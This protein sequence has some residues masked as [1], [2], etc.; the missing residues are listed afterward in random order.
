M[1]TPK[2]KT[3]G[4]KK[5]ISTPVS[6]D[7]NLGLAAENNHDFGL[8]DS[9]WPR[10]DVDPA[11]WDKYC[12]YQLIIVEASEDQ[13]KTSYQPYKGW[14]YTLPLPP[15]S[16]SI[17][18]PFAIQL[19]PTLGGFIEEHNGA[20]L[21]MI[22]IRGTTGFLPL[23]S[24]PD[25][26]EGS[27]ASKEAAAIFGGTVTVANN[28]RSDYSS[29]QSAFSNTGPTA[30]N[31][32][33]EA[34]FSSSS[35]EK[36][37]MMTSGFV[38]IS[39][40]RN[41]LEAYAAIKKTPRGSSL[42]LAVA[43]WKEDQVYLVTPMGFG[44]SKD[45]SSPMEYRYNLSFKA[46]KR[47]KLEAGGYAKL[48]PK[49]IRRDP[50]QIARAI[51]TLT[52]ARRMVQNIGALKQGLLGDVDYVF[53]PLHDVIL[54]GKDILGT[55]LTLAEIPLA[56]RQRVTIN[57]MELQYEYPDLYNEYVANLPKSGVALNK[58]TTA[59]SKILD[60]PEGYRHSSVIEQHGKARN[61][62]SN[63]LSL[64]DIPPGLA[65]KLPLQSLRLP[66]DA[67]NDIKRDLDRVR[68]LTRKDFENYF[69]TMQNVVNK[70]T[71]LLGA[72]DADFNATYGISVNSTHTPTKSDWDTIIALTE[73]VEV[74][75]QFAATA[76][77][78]PDDTATLLE[79]YGDLATA[80]GVAWT[81]PVSKFSVPYPYSFTL[82]QLANQYLGNPD[83]WM[84]IAAMNG[85][86]APYIDEVGYTL[87]LKVN[88]V[89]EQV[90]VDAHTD[91]F[92][93]KY[94]WLGSNVLNKVKAQIQEIKALGATMALS[95]DV[96][97]TGYLVADQAYIECFLTG[98][99][100]SRNQIW[101]PS[102][103]DPVDADDVITKDIPGI[104]STD[105]MTG[106]GGV[107]ILLDSNND[108]VMENGDIKLVSG[109]SNIVQWV[110]ILLGLQ[111]T[112]LLQ[113][114][115]LGLGLEVGMSL[116][117]FD[118]EI[119]LK[120]IKEMLS[121]D[122]TFSSIDKIKIVQNGAN[123]SIDIGATVTGTTQPLPLSYGVRLG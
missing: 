92:I 10:V 52:A 87:S 29:L 21:R 40:L 120:G 58:F 84:E 108:I 33:A 88:A 80:S 26:L 39:L 34:D 77:G 49:P 62:S 22:Q 60:M 25:R 79:R 98:T 76:D 74:I 99:I 24:S 102:Q 41:F 97:A 50:N 19:T 57:V 54:L 91:L 51:N 95:L 36:S 115:S 90:I 6:M 38:Q 42:R 5:P 3:Q 106:V 1:D 122:S 70:V 103:L 20:P 17:D 56:V 11:K 111:K 4:V 107:D 75:Q 89:G 123:A 23:R 55:T 46:W 27:K 121:Q 82:E 47:I 15:E 2:S 45:A 18:T 101:I 71:A 93:G 8:E 110:R 105:P 112:E 69:N 63:K 28:A 114:P 31:V 67:L 118:P 16:L 13:G 96:D 100:N 66:Q 9:F 78:G 119:T 12:P 72:G 117:D 83:R 104:D 73:A 86:R 53:R 37:L 61:T 85:L 81:Q 94:V 65:E 14:Q 44:V 109:M 32:Y 59:S 116:A 48:Q 113:H 35:S 7:Q 30:S 68:N 43:I 64:T